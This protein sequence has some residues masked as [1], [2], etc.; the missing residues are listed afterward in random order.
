MALFASVG[1]PALAALAL[2]A[3]ALW[4][5]TQR[6]ADAPG[7]SGGAGSDAGIFGFHGDSLARQREIESLLLGLPDAARVE[8]HARFLTE[9]PHVAGTP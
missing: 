9:D 3:P 4:R 2:A 6:G 7:P 8:E 5:G 1:L